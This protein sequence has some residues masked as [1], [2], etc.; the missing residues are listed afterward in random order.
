MEGDFE[1]ETDYLIQEYK[2]S[3]MKIGILENKLNHCRQDEVDELAYELKAEQAR[4]GRIK[5][6]LTAA[7]A[8]QKAESDCGGGMTYE[9]NKRR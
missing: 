9:K 4:F 2:E 6:E 1:M 7:V 3:Q 5:R 8:Y